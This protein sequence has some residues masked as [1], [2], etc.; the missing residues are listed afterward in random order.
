[1]I[2]LKH[3][4]GRTI[5]SE[6]CATFWDHALGPVRQG[7]VCG[8]A[9]ER[10]NE[11]GRSGLSAHARATEQGTNGIAIDRSCGAL[12]PIERCEP[13]IV[14]GAW[15]G[16]VLDEDRDRLHETCLGGVVEGGR[17][18]CV[19]RL[20]RESPV[21]RTRAMAKERGDVFGII[22]SALISRA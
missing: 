2:S 22:F 17:A 18:P 11:P 14:L 3:L 10:V 1:V 8:W 16:A 9:S 21:I 5:L 19:D 13:V 6:K 7:G 4:F 12:E 20:A 15:I